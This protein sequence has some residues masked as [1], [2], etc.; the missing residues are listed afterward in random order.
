[1]CVC[2]CIYVCV[3]LCERVHYVIDVYEKNSNVIN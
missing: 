3:Y 1:M 2:V